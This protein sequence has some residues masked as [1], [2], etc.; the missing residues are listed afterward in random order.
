MP[1][2]LVRQEIEVRLTPSGV[3]CFFKGKRVAAHRRSPHRGAHSTVPE[4]MPASH[5]AHAE[6]TPGRML[7]WAATLGSATTQIVRF[8][9]ESRPHPEQGYRACLGIMRLARQYGP[10]RLEAACARAIALGAHRYKS[11]ASIL[12]AGLDRQPLPGAQPHELILPT[13]ANVRGASYYH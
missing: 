6:W 7:N 12:K 3:E 11:V 13:H 9:L 8:Q 1:H 10:E 2:T 5:R 4:H